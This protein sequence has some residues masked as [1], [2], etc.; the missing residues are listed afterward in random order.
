MRVWHPCCGRDDAICAEFMFHILTWCN[1]WS[2]PHSDRS[3]T[4][5]CHSGGNHLYKVNIISCSLY[6]Q[7]SFVILR[8]DFVLI[9]PIATWSI[10]R[11]RACLI[12]LTTTNRQEVAFRLIWW[13]VVP[14]REDNS[15]ND[16]I[17]ADFVCFPANSLQKDHRSTV[18]EPYY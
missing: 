8:L 17:G 6:V 9:R 3:A 18:L 16:M 4:P 12:I 10:C 1:W 11:R 15:S 13:R 7:F 5:S 2:W 14:I